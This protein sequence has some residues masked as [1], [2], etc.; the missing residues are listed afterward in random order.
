VLVVNLLL[1][2]S[3]VAIRRSWEDAIGLMDALTWSLTTDYT[4]DQE[5][6]TMAPPDAC[7]EA[8]RAEGMEQTFR[9]P[10]GATL[11]A[12][13]DESVLLVLA[14]GTV[15]GETGVAAS[16]SVVMQVAGG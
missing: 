9:I 4:R 2:D 12:A 15:N 3:R 11:C 6:E 5:L 1:T 7:L 10:A 14:Y 16:D 8:K 13:D